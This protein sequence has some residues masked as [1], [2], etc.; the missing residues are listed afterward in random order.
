M[1]Q[2]KQQEA[3][4]M[5]EIIDQNNS[6]FELDNKRYYLSVIEVPDECRQTSNRKPVMKYNQTAND[7]NGK[8]FS[9]DD[10]VEMID[11]GVL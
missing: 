4:I 2:L 3:E 7:V 6:F 5:K 8:N 10:V 9:I 1:K 11:L